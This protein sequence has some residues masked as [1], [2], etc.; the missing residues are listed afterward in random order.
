MEKLKIFGT[1]QVVFN[2]REILVG[3]FFG[4]GQSPRLLSAC[5]ILQV[6]KNFLPQREHFC[7]LWHKG[8]R[9]SLKSATT[10]IVRV[11][12]NNVVQDICFNKIVCIVNILY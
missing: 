5:S 4:F 7:V 10:L 8:V 9:E 1:K 12:V 3:D 11:E 2:A 6:S